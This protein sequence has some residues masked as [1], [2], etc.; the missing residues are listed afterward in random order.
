MEWMLLIFNVKFIRI[1]GRNSNNK[2]TIRKYKFY[3]AWH[4]INNRMNLEDQAKHDLFDFD[5]FDVPTI[6]DPYRNNNILKDSNRPIENWT[7][8]THKT[9]YQNVLNK[10]HQAEFNKKS[11]NNRHSLKKLLERL[12]SLPSP[13]RKTKKTQN[14]KLKTISIMSSTE[15]VIIKKKGSILVR[16]YI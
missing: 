13:D 4:K 2:N 16:N 1:H 8:P 3:L 7:R 11:E 14:P 12:Q 5:E 15:P 9:F 10:K 6:Y